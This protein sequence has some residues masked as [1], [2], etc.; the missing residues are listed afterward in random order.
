MTK[1]EFI[2][3]LG[4]H[5]G[6]E[7]THGQV[8]FFEKVCDFLASDNFSEVFMLKGF[9]G[10]GKTSVVSALVKT[11]NHTSLKVVL[12]AP[13]GRAAKVMSNYSG[14]TASTIHRLIY[15][16]RQVENKTSLILKQ[17]KFKNTL[18]VADEASMIGQ[19]NMEDPNQRNLLEDLLMFVQEGERCK[20]LLIGDEAQ[21]PPVGMEL[22]PALDQEVLQSG[23]FVQVKQQN[24]T[25]VVRQSEDSGILHNA[26]LVREA[27][28]REDLHWPKLEFE[29]F[30]D[31][32]PVDG[33]ELADSLNDAYSKYGREGVIVV[34]RSNKNA[35]L[36]NRQIRNRVFWLED[37]LAVGDLIM[38][39]KNNYF[40]LD[41][42]DGEID[43]IANGEMMEIMKLGNIVERY[44]C[45]FADAT[46]RFC[47]YSSEITAEIKLNLSV[48]DAP[49]ASMSY[50]DQKQ[51]TEEI[52]QDYLHIA[53]KRE[54]WKQIKKDPYFN[55]LQ[56]KFSYAVTCHKSQGGQ[57]PCVFV[58]MGYMP[59]EFPQRE[60]LRWLYTALSRATDSLYLI[61][62]R[63]DILPREN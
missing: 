63:K 38:A 10:T 9:A 49:Q 12:L 62:F 34:T 59:E 21:L 30:R 11:L 43:F 36:Y 7:P 19:E 35:V 60:D 16:V 33:Y 23:Y 45:L 17:N 58:D 55:A 6:H 13:T 3:L 2:H 48:L 42:F 5:L 15:M 41:G 56:I 18:F 37:Q 51:M 46:V 47:D 50:K 39:V 22:S 40:W 27:L 54:R 4:I 8:V 61:N 57:W 52:E 14:K 32:I 29:Q 24:L 20:L 26:T 25:E 31:V 44:G 53:L 1:K 28:T